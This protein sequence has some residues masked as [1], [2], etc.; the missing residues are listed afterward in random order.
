MTVKLLLLPLS[1]EFEVLLAKCGLIMPKVSTNAAFAKFSSG[2][3]RFCV[4]NVAELIALSHLLFTITDGW[5]LK[6]HFI[7]PC[8]VIFIDTLR[9]ISRISPI[10]VVHVQGRPRVLQLHARLI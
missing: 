7:F 6:M 1:H 5:V 8:C 2:F 10:V 3:D 4:S 9:L